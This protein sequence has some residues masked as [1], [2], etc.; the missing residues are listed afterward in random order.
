MMT[1]NNY[2]ANHCNGIDTGVHIHI[3]K[4]V[5]N[6]D[7]KKIIDNFSKMDMFLTRKTSTLYGNSISRQSH[8]EHQHQ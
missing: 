4:N 7:V 6:F 2:Q 1:Y 5:D 8:L 3:E